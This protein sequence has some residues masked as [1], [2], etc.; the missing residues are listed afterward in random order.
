MVLLSEAMWSSL[1]QLLFVASLGWPSDRFSK[2]SA[3][4]R[5]HAGWQ[6]FGGYATMHMV[7][8]RLD[9][10]GFT[11]SNEWHHSDLG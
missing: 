3:V 2:P 8:T 1:I 11:N 6:L 4:V 5:V 10:P 9:L 7:G